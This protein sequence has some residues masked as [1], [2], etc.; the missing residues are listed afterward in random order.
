MKNKKRNVLII[1]HEA[2]IALDIKERLSNQGHTIIGIASSLQEA[3]LKRKNF[4]KVDL[5]LIDTSLSDFFVELNNAEKIYNLI[6]TPLILMVS[7][8]KEKI[9][10]KCCKYK[11]VQIIEKPFHDEEFMDAVGNI[12]S[13]N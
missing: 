5:I 1:E 6:R 10:E 11:F 4:C 3:I 13:C 8:T 9:K 7:N 2:I 12:L